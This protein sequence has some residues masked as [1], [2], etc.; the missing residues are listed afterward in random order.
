MQKN[1]L[2][3]FHVLANTAI[4]K[5]LRENLKLITTQSKANTLPLILFYFLKM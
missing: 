2:L 4:P 5:G 1:S 3:T